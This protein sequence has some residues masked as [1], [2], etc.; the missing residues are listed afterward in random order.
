[1][2]VKIYMQL[3]LYISLQLTTEAD[4]CASS[5]CPG[6]QF[7]CEDLF[8]QYKC[9]CIVGFQGVN[10]TQGTCIQMAQAIIRKIIANYITQ[11]CVLF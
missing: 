5:P 6:A 3:D 8:N 2:C 4:E 9:N 7:V 10:C 11:C 1:M